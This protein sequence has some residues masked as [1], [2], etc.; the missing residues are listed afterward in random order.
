MR[1]LLDSHT[2][3]WLYSGNER[4]SQ[5]AKN[6]IEDTRNECFISLASIWEMAIKIKLGKMNLGVSLDRFVEDVV[7][8]GIQLLAV[9]LVHVLKTQELDFHHR[10]PFDRLIFSQ[11]ISENMVLLSADV[12]ADLYFANENV[13]RIW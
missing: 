11:A 2:L 5:A 6:V 1:I 8:N 4:L 9:D 13:K 10:D 12:I 7:E 3:I